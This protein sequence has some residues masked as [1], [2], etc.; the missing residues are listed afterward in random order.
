MKSF[1]NVLALAVL[2][3]AAFVTAPASAAPPGDSF[4]S[5]AD[6]TAI[7]SYVSNVGVA[8]IAAAVPVQNE[9]LALGGLDVL[10]GS[11]APAKKEP[12]KKGGGKKKVLAAGPGDDDSDGGGGDGQA[13]MRRM[14]T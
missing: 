6:S 11:K 14:L 7:Q 12:A 9:H 2:A 1:R 10:A 5:A 3:C 4:M 13:A 8:P